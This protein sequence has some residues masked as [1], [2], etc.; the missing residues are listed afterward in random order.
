MACRSGASPAMASIF[1]SVV[2]SLEIER[3]Y[4]YYLITFNVPTLTISVLAIIGAVLSAS[5]TL[6]T[7][8]ALQAS[9]RRLCTTASA[10]RSAPWASRRCSP[11]P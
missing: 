4:G 10:S 9:Y 1:S 8:R 2:V 5:R 3:N 11:W 7:W 6:S